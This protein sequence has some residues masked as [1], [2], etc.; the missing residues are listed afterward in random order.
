M[1]AADGLKT[2]GTL[3]ESYSPWIKA[4]DGWPP[5]A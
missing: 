1:I 5:Q 2:N 3:A 4:A